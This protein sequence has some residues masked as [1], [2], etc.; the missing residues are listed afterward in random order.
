MF[1][2][3]LRPKNFVLKKTFFFVPNFHCQKMNIFW[4]FSIKLPLYRVQQV[5][6]INPQS[7]KNFKARYFEKYLEFGDNIAPSCSA[8]QYF[9]S[10]KYEVL[11]PSHHEDTKN[12]YLRSKTWYILQWET[13]D[14]LYNLNHKSD[15]FCHQFERLELECRSETAKIV[16]GCLCPMCQLPRIKFWEQSEH[17]R[18]LS[19]IDFAR[20]ILSKNEAFS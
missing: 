2:R 7:H 5:S 9:I 16:V 6:F 20:P 3:S 19:E 14:S 18:L 12:Q 8:D 11:T 10:S 17:S 13:I 1:G 4:F 15:S